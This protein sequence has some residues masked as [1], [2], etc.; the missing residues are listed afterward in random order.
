MGGPNQNANE[1]DLRRELNEFKNFLD[2]RGQDL[3]KTSEFLQ[4]Y[5]LPYVQNPLQHPTFR[6]VC[7]K[8]WATEL[9]NKLKEFLEA[10]I[11]KNQ[12]PQLFHWYANFKKRAGP[13]DLGGGSASADA[14]ELKERLLLMQRHYVVLEKKEEYAKSTLIESQSKWTLFSKDILNI[15]KELLQTMDAFQISQSMNKVP[16]DPIREK[17]SRYEAFL[18]HNS[19]EIQ[20]KHGINMT[21]PTFI[22][23]YQQQMGMMSSNGPDQ[24]HG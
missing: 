2:T 1:R 22:E 4:Y 19:D 18:I 23:N 5:A 10:N 17:L 9:R 12:S 14:E 8:K 21:K 15:A 20:R 16:M 13:S 3:S 11:P 7:S 24:M 6:A